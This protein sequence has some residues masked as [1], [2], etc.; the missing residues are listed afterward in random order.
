MPPSSPDDGSAQL[1]LPAAGVELAMAS[2][3]ASSDVPSTGEQSEAA[4]ANPGRS[5][6]R[7]TLEDKQRQYLTQMSE[8]KRQQVLQQ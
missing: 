7:G 1:D 5:P 6:R 4:L 8:K 3:A 2:D